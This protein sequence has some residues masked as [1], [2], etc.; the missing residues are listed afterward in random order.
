MRMLRVNDW[1]AF[2]NL[3]GLKK[4]RRT[5]AGKNEFRRSKL[6]GIRRG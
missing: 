4:L 3:A 5:G 2:V 6:R 1:L